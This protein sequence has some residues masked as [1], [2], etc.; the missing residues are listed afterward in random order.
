V[1]PSSLTARRW[2]AAVALAA[3]VLVAA[4]GLLTQ[5]D[6]RLAV[7]AAEAARLAAAAS[8]LDQHLR[9]GDEPKAIY[10]DDRLVKVMWYRDGRAV[11][12]AGVD[13]YQ[14][15]THRGLLT[16]RAGWG[17]A[18]SHSLIMLAGLTALFLLVTLR[19]PLRRMRTLDVLALAA[20]VVPAVLIDRGYLG[21]AEGLAALLLL[22]LGAR[23]AWLAVRGPDRAD[24]P[25]APVLLT[26]AAAR[27]RLPRLPA[28]LALT[29]LAGTLLIIVTS[30]G[31]VDIAIADMEGATVLAHGVLPYGHMPGDIVHGDT[32]GLP[33]YALYA[34]FAAIWPMTS[35]WDDP[36]GALVPN[37]IV[38]CVCLAGAAG[39]TRGA[40]WP[41]L[42]ALLAFPAALMGSSSGT[43]DVVIAAM[44]IWAFAWW[45]R[46]AASSALV[47]LAGTAKVAPLVLLPLWLAR[48]RGTEL[49]RALVASAAVG[50]VVLAG[51]VA[52]GGLHGPAAMLHA[53]A[54]QFDRRSELSIWTGLG[55]QPLQPLAQGLALALVAGG[56][57]L[58][59]LDRAVAADPRR[60][61]GLVTAVLAAL[62]VAANH[63]APLYLMW[64]APPALIALLGPL[65]ATAPQPV[66]ERADD[67][68]TL[69]STPT[70]A[71][72]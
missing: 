54:F 32:Y 61:A 64:F 65:G 16:S 4:V 23:G 70:L 7:P 14:G 12:T 1:G 68:A 53:I 60:V 43:N 31:I 24:D 62:Q 9:P 40:R 56:T 26:A 44:L 67:E 11:A 45:T 48:L 10:V 15:V 8:P 37:A 52:L 29:L 57:V 50:A 41:A 18:I 35:D 22:Y 21:H 66:A 25:D 2:A 30:N 63:W 58:V 19:G 13:R 17:A 46:P 72:V 20:L 59:W 47:M 27:W 69:P 51:L 34:P 5:R 6:H 49:R 39:A 42:L 28:Q 55:L 38:V 36:I 33:I 3:F 71:P